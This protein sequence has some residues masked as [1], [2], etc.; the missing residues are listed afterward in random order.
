MAIQWRKDNLFNSGPG[1]I[2]HPHAK[3]KNVDTN[4][5]PHIKINELSQNGLYK[6]KI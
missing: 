2:G 5:I 6:Y 4:L 1:A 3:K